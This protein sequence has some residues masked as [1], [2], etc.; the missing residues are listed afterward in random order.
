MERLCVRVPTQPETVALVPGAQQQL[1][2]IVVA[3]VDVR[4]L[5]YGLL[6]LADR[7]R[8]GDDP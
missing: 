2:Y 5:V 7:V 4:G 8:L 1:P 6:E 3:S